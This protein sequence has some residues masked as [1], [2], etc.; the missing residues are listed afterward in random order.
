VGFVQNSGH[1]YVTGNTLASISSIASPRELAKVKF[2]L[3]ESQ[4]QG[5]SPYLWAVD[6]QVHHPGE[7]ETTYTT[8]G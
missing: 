6:L 7:R 2:L 1:G 3:G 8:T 4:A 5:M